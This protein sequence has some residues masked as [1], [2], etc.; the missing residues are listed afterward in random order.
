MYLMWEAM[1]SWLGYLKMSAEKMAL[2]LL[3]ISSQPVHFSLRMPT[4]AG[5]L[6]YC[7]ARCL[8]LFSD[9]HESIMFFRTNCI[10]NTTSKK[11]QFFVW[12]KLR[13]VC[14][15]E[16]A[17]NLVNIIM[18]FLENSDL[19]IKINVNTTFYDG[20]VTLWNFLSLKR[21]MLNR[22]LFIV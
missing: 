16:L 9:C 18:C 21:Y 17:E 7:P 14:C 22:F 8:L 1:L 6:V 11:Q 4:F 10:I 15:I 2:V 12:R 3:D 20:F 19:Y 13:F 5:F